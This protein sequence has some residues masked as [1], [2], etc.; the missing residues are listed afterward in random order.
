M[1]GL[2]GQGEKERGGDASVA[3]MH[4]VW[5]WGRFREECR[6]EVYVCILLSML[7]CVHAAGPV[8]VDPAC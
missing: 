3:G 6:L 1:V 4:L 8:G 5:V 2:I 7:I